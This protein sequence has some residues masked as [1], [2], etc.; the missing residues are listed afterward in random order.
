MSHEAYFITYSFIFAWL[1][2]V[3]LSFK[4]V[5]FLKLLAVF[6]YQD[7]FFFS[8]FKFPSVLSS[9]NPFASFSNPV[10]S[11]RCGIKHIKIY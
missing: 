4:E 1:S 3:D 8:T 11:Y 5:I 2:V 10:R 9:P 6:P 7:F